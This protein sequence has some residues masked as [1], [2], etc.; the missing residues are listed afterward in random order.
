MIGAIKVLNSN[1]TIFAGCIASSIVMN[2]QTIINELLL[3]IYYFTHQKLKIKRND[4]VEVDFQGFL[5]S[6][7]N[8]VVWNKKCV[9]VYAIA[10]KRKMINS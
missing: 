7:L 8:T 9:Q 10:K 6:L 3:F 5:F 2:G 4:L 1:V